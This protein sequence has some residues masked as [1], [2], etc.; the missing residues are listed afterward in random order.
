MEH[1]RFVGLDI[2][3]EWISIAVPESGRS[4]AV[5]YLDEI[6]N[7]PVP[8]GFQPPK[9]GGVPSLKNNPKPVITSTE[10]CRRRLALFTSPIQI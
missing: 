3:T 7:D 2:H 4:D 9:V 8:L 1:T 5:E 10:K 6:S